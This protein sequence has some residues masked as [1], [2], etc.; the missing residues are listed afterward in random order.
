MSRKY[1]SLIVL[2]AFMMLTFLPTV[3]AQ[4]PSED[5]PTSG[6]G[7]AGIICLMYLCALIVPSIIMII[8]TIWVYNDASKLGVENPWLWGL[9]VFLTG[10]IGLI[11]YLVA[12]RPK[13]MEQDRRKQ[14]FSSGYS[15][16]PVDMSRKDG[17][18][19]HC[20]KF[21]GATVGRCTFCGSNL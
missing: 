4:A 18:C 11:V 17:Y 15:N 19:P 1:L 13:A 14:S 7:V 12:I 6:D 5:P 3:L 21:V 10:I 16:D 8:L 9:L 2:I 20:G